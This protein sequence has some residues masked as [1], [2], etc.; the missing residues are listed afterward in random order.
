MILAY[1]MAYAMLFLTQKRIPGNGRSRLKQCFILNV[2]HIPAR[3]DYLRPSLAAG[4]AVRQRT[5]YVLY[6]PGS[7]QV[8]GTTYG[9][10]HPGRVPRAE[11][12]YRK[13]YLCTSLVKYLKSNASSRTT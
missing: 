1:A 9:C 13:S 12:F 6:V 11:L 4:V 2:F 3:T 10:V 5:I 7:M 8:V